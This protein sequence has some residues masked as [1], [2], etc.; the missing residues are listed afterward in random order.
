MAHAFGKNV[1]AG[2]RSRQRA[3]DRRGGAIDNRGMIRDSNAAVGCHSDARLRRYSKPAVRRPNHHDWVIAS[4]MNG[5]GARRA[6]AHA[7]GWLSI[8]R[9]R[10]LKR[11]S[12]IN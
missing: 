7:G 4:L 8:N 11:L 2:L 3:Y 10:R 6:R 1:Q 9:V 12:L 5:R